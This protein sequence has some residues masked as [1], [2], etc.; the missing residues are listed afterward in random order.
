MSLRTNV[1]MVKWME[2]EGEAD[3]FLSNYDWANFGMQVNPEDIVHADRHGAVV[4]PGQHLEA[5]P[6]AIALMARREKVVL[7]AAKRPDFD[8]STLKQALADSAKVS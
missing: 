8:I 2:A 4:I 6:A 1:P 7:D 5:I 3:E